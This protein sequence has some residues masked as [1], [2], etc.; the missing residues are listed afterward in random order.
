MVLL[1]V[2]CDLAIG[3]LLLA[4]LLSEEVPDT[5]EC[6]PEFRIWPRPDLSG[7]D[8]RR[9][10]GGSRGIGGTRKMFSL[11]SAAEQDTKTRPVG[12]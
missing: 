8:I 3:L 11:G 12:D 7:D 6:E 2:Q 4:L 9:P 1:R 5:S 10:K